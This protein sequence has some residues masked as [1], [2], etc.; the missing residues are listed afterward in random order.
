MEL[1]SLGT[2]V[3]GCWKSTSN[4]PVLHCLPWGLCTHF[5]GQQLREYFISS[6]HCS[7]PNM[8]QGFFCFFFRARAGREA[9][10]WRLLLFKS[11][12][13]SYREKFESVVCLPN[14]MVWWWGS[15]ITVHVKIR[16]KKICIYSSLLME[17]AFKAN[18]IV[19]FSLWKCQ[20]SLVFCYLIV[21]QKSIRC[22]M[23]LL[24]KAGLSRKVCT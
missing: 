17:Q 20:C 22:F 4:H 3:S 24:Q 16:E 18:K 13:H 1:M 19:F 7:F 9:V 8:Q 21:L 6:R 23:V 14:M 10:V 5:Q 2:I 12:F 15:S 11:Q